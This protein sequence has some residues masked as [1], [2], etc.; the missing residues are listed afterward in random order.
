MRPSAAGPAGCNEGRSLAEGGMAMGIGRFA[1]PAPLSL[2]GGP[3][4]C[5]RT[6]PLLV[7]WPSAGGLAPCWWTARLQ[8]G[9]P[10]AGGLAPIAGGLFACKGLS[11]C[12]GPSTCTGLSTCKGRPTCKGSSPFQGSSTSQGL[13]Y[14]CLRY[15]AI[16]CCPSAVL[17]STL[18]CSTLPI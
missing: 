1:N 10:I 14:S 2:A 17:H 7:D 18:L 15:S 6:C 11:T 9:W 5:R 4:P 3:V 8:V 16:F 13:V 12:K